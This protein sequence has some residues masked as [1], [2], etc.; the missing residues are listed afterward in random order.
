GG[1]EVTTLGTQPHGVGLTETSSLSTVSR[2]S[3]CGILL[4]RAIVRRSGRVSSVRERRRLRK[5]GLPRKYV[6]G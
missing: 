4:C 2:K 3:W 5:H 6:Y 1:V